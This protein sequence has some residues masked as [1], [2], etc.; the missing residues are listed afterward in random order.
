MP[1]GLSEAT[2]ALPRGSC[3]DGWRRD[4][5]TEA[6]NLDVLADLISKRGALAQGLSGRL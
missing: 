3:A 1:L 4:G 6:Q 5:V 2:A